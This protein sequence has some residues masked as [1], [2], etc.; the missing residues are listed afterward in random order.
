[1]GAAK[2]G[3]TAGFIGKVGD[4]PFGYY[5][6]KVLQDNNVDTSY[7]IHDK[8]AR[9]TLSYV[10]LKSGGARDCMFYRNP[11]ADMLLSADEIGEEYFNGAS[12]F[13]YGSISLGSPESEKATLK[14]IE[15]AR[16][17][18]VTIAYDPNLR[19]SL[20]E[21]EELAREKINAGFEFADL[22]KIS[23]EEF[24]FITGT[25]SVEECAEYLLNK[26]CKVVLITL[27]ADGCY[28]SDG[29]TSGYISG[30]KVDTVETTGAGD[31]FW[32]G[33]LYNVTMRLKKDR[34]RALSIDE[35][36][37]KAVKFANCA[38]ALATTKMGAIPAMPTTEEVERLLLKIEND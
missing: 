5:L 35:E 23:D 33:V 16:K 21:S 38:G 10:A 9:T 19:L 22:V 7:L 13:H 26:G 31:A 28:Y 17:N 2:L 29:K 3:L 14:A 6:K 15:Y 37:I 32:A 12:I 27:G 4:D 20:W 34:G 1:V 24:K 36:F 18:N 30:V 8:Y 11:G 25:D